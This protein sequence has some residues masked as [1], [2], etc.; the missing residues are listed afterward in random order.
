MPAVKV[1]GTDFFAV[2]EAADEAIARARSG[3]GPSTIEMDAPR[4]RGH[5]E[6]DPQMYRNLDE[7]KELR[8]K[9]DCLK[10]FRERVLADK[11]MTVEELDAI[12]QEV[13][14]LI[15]QSVAEAKAA[16][17]PLPEDL[18]TDVYINY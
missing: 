5:F 12:D 8:E 13:L 1:D 9:R 4:W 7:I 11:T 15:E 17:D 3:G 2:Y 14:D 18:T 6:G 10:K 16:P